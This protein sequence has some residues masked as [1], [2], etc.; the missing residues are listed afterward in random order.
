MLYI[1]I[2]V[3][4]NNLS[5]SNLIGGLKFKNTLPRF[6]YFPFGGGIRGRTGESFAWMEGIVAVASISKQW[7]M[8]LASNQRVDLDAEITLRP[9]YGMKVKVLYRSRK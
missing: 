9:K 8:R 4:I 5:N 3:I 6:A 2:P 1:M 7:I